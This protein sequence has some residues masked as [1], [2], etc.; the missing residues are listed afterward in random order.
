MSNVDGGDFEWK[1]EMDN[2]V[3]SFA[4]LVKGS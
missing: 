4:E 3:K 2:F 1:S